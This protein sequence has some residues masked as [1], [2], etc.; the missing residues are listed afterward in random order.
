MADT[1]DSSDDDFDDMML[2]FML[3]RRRNRL[4]EKKKKKRKMWVRDIFKNHKNQ[5]AYHNLVQEMMF[6]DRES[7]FKYMRMSPERFEH[8]LSL[9]E[10]IVTKQTTNLRE[11]ISAGERLSVTLRF[12]AT[13]ESQQSLSFS[14]RIGKST[15]SKIIRETC[16]AIY[17]VL[18]PTYLRPP[19]KDK[20]RLVGYCQRF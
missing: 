16:D 6:S 3:L 10:P 18:A 9:I 4:L 13:G 20:G 2:M 12:L 7:Y 1:S 14:Y 15:A 8:L 5:G 11:P 17:T 19:R